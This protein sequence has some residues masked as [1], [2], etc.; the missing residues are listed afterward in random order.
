[1]AL[2]SCYGFYAANLSGSIFHAV[3]LSPG[4]SLVGLYVGAVRRFTL[5]DLNKIAPS[6]QR[7]LHAWRA[8][9]NV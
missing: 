6:L 5:C 7:M 4:Y 1:M 9:A 3:V 2:V 8:R